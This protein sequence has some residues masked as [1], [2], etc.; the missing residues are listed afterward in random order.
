M[1][2]QMQMLK[3][4]IGWLCEIDKLKGVYRQSYLLDKTRRE[5]SAEHSWHA[6]LAAL[7]L[8]QSSNEPVDITRVIKMLLLHDLVEIYAGDTFLYDSQNNHNDNESEQRAAEIIF[9]LLPSSQAEDLRLLWQE[10]DHMQTEDAKFAR[11]IDRLLPILHN[12]FNQGVTWTKKG[13]TKQQVFDR[14]REIA[15]GSKVLWEYA[16]GLIEDGE[17]RGYFDNPCF[18]KASDVSEYKI[19]DSVFGVALKTIEGLE[20]QLGGY[21][22]ECNNNEEEFVLIYNGKIK[23]PSSPILFRIN[24]ACFTG[25]IFHCNRCDCSWQ[26][27]KSMEMIAEQGGLIIYHLDHEGRG[28]GL[29]DKLKTYGVMDRDNKTTKEAFEYI[30]RKPD[31]RDYY[32]TVMILKDLGINSVRLISNNPQ[33]KNVLI[34]NGIEV[35][36]LVTLVNNQKSLK[37]YLSSKKEQFGHII[38]KID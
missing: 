29:V 18:S 21:K 38:D 24:S 3:Q 26:L 6:A 30:G 14:N 4:Q 27:H 36:E 5:N 11:S 20:L 32:P 28:I 10:F 9:G 19:I 37:K 13:I 12:Y 7:A 17:E 22:I 15:A 2:M 16:K 35:N 33:K 25:D 34:Q 31:E 1:Q 23:H 8:G